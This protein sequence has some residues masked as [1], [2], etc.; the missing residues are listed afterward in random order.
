MFE[1]FENNL[2]KSNANKCH[3]L[4]SSSDAVNLRVSEYD[5]NSECEK[6]LGVTFDNKLTFEKH[7]TDIFRKASR[8]IYALARVAPYMDLSKRRMVMNAFFNSQFNHCPLI[9]MCHNRTTD[10]KINRLHE[11]CLR[12]IYNDKQSSFK[13]LLEKDSSVSIHYRNIQCLATEMYNVSNGL[14]PPLVSNIFTEKNVI[15]TIFDLIPSFPDLLLGLYFTGPK[16]YPI[17][18]QL[19]GILFLIVTKPYQ[20]L[21]FLKTGLKNGNLK[22]VPAV[23][24]KHTFQTWLYIGFRSGKLDETLE[25]FTQ[26]SLIT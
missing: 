7:I 15:L 6:L 17:L 12:I 5:I 19:S 13:M 21:V 1:W 22:I 16:A 9:W 3:L 26:L 18:V 24:A 8:K 10:R 4:V 23:F 11:R 20:I 14:S 2:L 25:F